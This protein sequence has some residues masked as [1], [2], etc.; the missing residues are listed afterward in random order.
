[1]KYPPGHYVRYSLDRIR[2]SVSLF[3]PLFYSFLITSHMYQYVSC[4]YGTTTY[5]LKCIPKTTEFKTN[6]ICHH[7]AVIELLTHR[8]FP[9]L[10]YWAFVEIGAATHGKSKEV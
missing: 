4:Y 9:V 1:M 5:A 10:Q 6:R 3:L 7:C 8:I 2:L